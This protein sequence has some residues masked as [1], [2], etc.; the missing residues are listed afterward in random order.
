[1]FLARSC[2]IAKIVGIEE[3]GEAGGKHG[4]CHEFGEFCYKRLG[5]QWRG[6]RTENGLLSLASVPAIPKMGTNKNRPA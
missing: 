5:Q 2:K 4:W 6:K 1:M 3:T